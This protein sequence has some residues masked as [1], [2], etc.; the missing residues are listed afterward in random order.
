[1]SPKR[2]VRVP[3]GRFEVRCLEMLDEVAR[4]GRSIVV[5]RRGH[6]VARVVPITC[7]P[8]LRGSVVTQRDLVTPVG[9]PW[10]AGD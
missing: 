6:P 10:E 1:M 7:A 9:E 2:E 5:T 8:D 4:T 3:I